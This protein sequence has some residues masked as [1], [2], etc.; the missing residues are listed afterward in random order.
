MGKHGAVPAAGGRPHVG[1]HV[2]G[3]G[4]QGTT[5]GLRHTFKT[6]MRKQG[7][8]KYW[9]DRINMGNGKD[10]SDSYGGGPEELPEMAEYV[11][12]VKY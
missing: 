1:I 7:V 9:T 8:P 3:V 2:R 10:I 6:A 4:I 11:S 12:R 5:S